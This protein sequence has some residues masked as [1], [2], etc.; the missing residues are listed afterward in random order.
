MQSSIFRAPSIHVIH[1]ILRSSFDSMY[2]LK[3]FSLKTSV[4]ETGDVFIAEPDFGK[5]LTVAKSNH[6]RQS[7]IQEKV[8]NYT[9][10][11]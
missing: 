1:I 11:Q 4:I 6:S 9:M 3:N 7:V 5:T 8:K 2:P 10:K